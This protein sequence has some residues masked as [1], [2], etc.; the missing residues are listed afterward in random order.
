LIPGYDNGKG[1]KLE[2]PL[3]QSAFSPLLSAAGE[4]RSQYCPCRSHAILADI[5]GV[6]RSSPLGKP[7]ARMND[8]S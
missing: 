3:A 1:L 7:D 5:V 2:M 8:D 6:T 4:N